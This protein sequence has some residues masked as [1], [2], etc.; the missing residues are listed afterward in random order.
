[1]YVLMAVK[2]KGSV[3]AAELPEAGNLRLNLF[4]E[5]TGDAPSPRVHGG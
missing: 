2:V 1:M 3:R 5:L 4:V